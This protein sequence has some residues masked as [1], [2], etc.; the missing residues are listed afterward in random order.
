MYQSSRADFESLSAI[1]ELV[2]LGIRDFASGACGSEEGPERDE[3]SLFSQ[4]IHHGGI[5]PENL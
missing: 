2:H 1:S 5:I 4:L 3:T